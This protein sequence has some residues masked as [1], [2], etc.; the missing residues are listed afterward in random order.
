MYSS[1]WLVLS[2]KH[3][4]V[5]SSSHTPHNSRGVKLGFWSQMTSRSC[6][7]SFYNYYRIVWAVVGKKKVESASLWC[8]RN[9]NP[10]N[11]M[12]KKIKRKK[13][14]TVGW[15]YNLGLEGAKAAVRGGLKTYPGEWLLGG[16]CFLLSKHGSG[17][18]P[19]APHC[20]LLLGTPVLSNPDPPTAPPCLSSSGLAG[21]AR[22]CPGDQYE[23]CLGWFMVWLIEKE[24]KG[25]QVSAAFYLA[26][27]KA[28]SHQHPKKQ[29][30]LSPYM[31]WKTL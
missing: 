17:G 13:I 20:T 25:R 11:Y 3:Y 10:V 4:M 12:K 27:N 2:S 23:V 16:C 30:L 29:L 15:G 19:R 26:M 14:N 24:S 8:V 1:V 5:L 22:L 28:F 18:G 21:F 6:F 31:L 7:F 9:H